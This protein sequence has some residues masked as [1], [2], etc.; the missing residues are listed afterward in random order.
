MAKLN[1]FVLPSFSRPGSERAKACLTVCKAPPKNI[2]QQQFFSFFHQHRQLLGFLCCSS[3]PEFVLHQQPDWGVGELQLAPRSRVQVAWGLRYSRVKGL[4]GRSLPSWIRQEVGRSGAAVLSIYVTQKADSALLPAKVSK[5]HS[6]Q[7]GCVGVFRVSWNMGQEPRPSPVQ[8]HGARG[9]SVP[10]RHHEGSLRSFFSP[11][12]FHPFFSELLCSPVSGTRRGAWKRGPSLTWGDGGCREETPERL[13]GG[14]G[15]GGRAE[16][17]ESCTCLHNFSKSSRGMLPPN[18][19]DHH[20][21]QAHTFS[22]RTAGL[23]LKR[24]SFK[25]ENQ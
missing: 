15:V 7:F 13:W 25:G 8:P 12:I 23:R 3:Y 14:C 22:G 18:P 5:P 11:Q 4:A 6:R 17:Q 20:Q 2:H 9:A 1:Y 19:H 16:P 10:T 21:P 24:T